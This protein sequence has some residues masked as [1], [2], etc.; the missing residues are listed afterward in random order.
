MRI[1]LTGGCGFIGS[2]VVRHVIRHTGHE[3]VNVDCLTYAASPQALEH[4][5][6]SPRYR[7]ERHD[8]ADAPAMARLFAQ[9]R[10]D[11]VMHLAAESHVDRSIDMPSA[12]I[13]TNI[14]GTS[15]LL[16]A[17]RHYWQGLDRAAQARF[18]FHHI[19]T[20]EVFGALAPHD[21]PFTETTPYDPRSPYS[22]SK[23]SSDHLVRA[24]YHTYGLPTFVTNTTNNYGIWHFPEKLIP[25]TIINA[26]MGDPLPVYGAGQNIRDWLFVED[27]AEAL[28][29]ALQH[30]QPGET[31][32][33]GARQPRTNMQVVTS[34]CAIL[35]ELRPDPA[36]RHERL[37][38]HVHDRPGHDFRY[39]IDPTHAENALGWRPRHDFEQGLRRTVQWYLDHASWWQ[40]I[41]KERYAGQRLGQAAT[42]EMS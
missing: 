28:V 27:H 30:G 42:L 13:R 22:A 16:D 6:A 19:S 18:R 41:R 33:I 7:F 25:L 35:D 5:P 11:A 26:I 29:R 15:V 10:P 39:E 21:P 40:A 31:Y 9:Y 32:A 37:I 3:I 1:L 4:A 12:F 34:L 24:W 20:D 23:A 17:A 14:V 36:G 2:A 8:I 38:R